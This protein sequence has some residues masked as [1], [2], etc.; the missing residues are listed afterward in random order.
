ME[1]HRMSQHA[2]LATEF[3]RCHQLTQPEATIVKMKMGWSQT[4][5]MKLTGMDV[6]WL[7]DFVQNDLKSIEQ[8]KQT[9]GRPIASCDY[10]K[11]KDGGRNYGGQAELDTGDIWGFGSATRIRVMDQG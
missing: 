9:K 4:Q 2:T 5:A 1:G 6:D 8:T 7:P 11:T 10:R 3:A